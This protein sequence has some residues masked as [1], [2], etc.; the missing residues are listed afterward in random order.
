[1]ANM[2]VTVVDGNNVTVSLDRGVAGVGIASISLVVI[3]QANYLL[4]TYTNGTTQTVGPVGVI[5]YNA[6]SPIDITGSTIS[7]TTVPVNLGG[8]GQTTANAGLNALLPVQTS[9]A[10]KYLQTDGTNSSWDAISL[11]TADITGVLPVVNGG[12]G[13]TTSTGT[14]NTVLSTSPTLV[15]PVL[16]TPASG[17]LTNATGLPV[18]TGISG[19][20]TGIATFLATPSSANLAAALTDG[21]GTGAAVFATSPTLVTPALGTPASGVMTN[22]TGTAAGLTAGNVT[23]NAN[24]TGDITSVGNATAIAAGVIV[25]A[26]INASA[27]IDDTKLATI[28][29]ALK[30]SNSATTAASTNTASAIVARDASGNFT[31]GTVTAAL[32]GNSSTATAL[33][34]G[35]TIEI[36]GDLAY[37]SPSF[38]GTGNVTAAGTL[39]T[40]ATAGVTGSSTA[41][42]VVTINAKGLTTSITTAAVIAPAGTLSG[43]T[44]AA[45]VTGSSLTSLGTIANLSVTAGTISTTPSASTDI[46]NKDYVDNVAQGLDPKASCVAATTAN[47]TLSGTQTIDGVALIAADR[48]L[49]KDQTAPA[50]NGI[51]VVAA[52]AWARAADM[53]VWLEVPGAFT[54]IEQGTLYADTGW[55]CTS[56]AGGTLGTTAITFVQFAGAGS[57]TASTG[58][59]LT[60]TAFSLTAPVTVALGGTNATSAGIASFN[61]ITGYTAA[62]ATGT[63]S[64]NL[65]FSTS[66]TLV[67]PILGTPQSAT[68]TNATGLPISTGVSGM[69]TGIATALAVNVGTAGSPV[70]NG[71]VLGSPST[72]GTM[73][74]FT[75]GGTVSGGGNQINNV[76][77]GASTPLAGAFTTGSFGTNPSATGALRLPNAQAIRWRNAANSADGFYLM[78]SASD[79]LTVFDAANTNI[80]TFSS[81]GLAVTG[82]L[83]ATGV[84]SVTGGSTVYGTAAQFG[85]A[86]AQS[87]SADSRFLFRPNSSTTV[88]GIRIVCNSATRADLEAGIFTSGGVFSTPQTLSLSPNGGLTTIG[89]AISATGVA[90]FSAGTAALPAITTTGD[91]NTGIFFPAADTIAFTEGGAESMRIT[92][93]GSVAIGTTTA[94]STLTVNGTDGI[95]MQRSTANA[96]APVLD[97]LKSRGTTA[98]PAGVSDGD[99][100]FLLRVAPYQGSAFTYLNAMTIE[101]DGTYTAGQNPPTRQIFYTNAANGSATE[102]LRI[103]S[104]GNVGIGTSSPNVKLHVSGTSTTAEI[105]V[106]S[107]STV[108]AL[109]FYADSAT[110]ATRNW[111]IASSFNAFGDLAFQQSNVLG[112]NPLTAGTTRMMLDASGNLG[113][114]TTSPATR[115]HLSQSNAGNYA[116]VI[117]LSNSADSS[118]DRTGIYGSAAPGNALPYRGGITFYPGAS[119]AVSIHT[120]N[121]ASPTTGQAAY[122]SSNQTA[123][124]TASISVGNATPTASGAGITFPATQSASTDANTLDDYEEGTWTPNQ[125]AGLTVVGTFSSTGNYVKVGKMVTVQV[126]LAATTSIT[127]SAGDAIM[128]TN[129]PF[130]SSPTRNPGVAVNTAHQAGLFVNIASTTVYS[131]G[132]LV[133]SATIFLS[134]TYQTS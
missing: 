68:L 60:G 20:G 110:A 117:L 49:V 118:A 76:V 56:N 52:G 13:V 15:T 25:N 43:S 80:G 54:F 30:V 29:T 78:Q 47:I 85:V 23:T 95:T 104:S 50:E 79:A 98:S 88:V 61:N 32:T 105:R 121:N 84:V 73:P 9:Q 64:T 83:S 36:T 62:G 55:V 70:V 11:S 66:P 1:M 2:Q 59:T 22:V 72:A 119:G 90:T 112:G 69:G 40:V 31:A 26:D 87:G 82:T 38:D 4:I 115:L 27:A 21:T 126:S 63:T 133:A 122:F 92:S 6:T 12:T 109:S 28:S 77:I 81:T 51:Y 42:P 113:I 48:C 14:G 93:A 18:A 100:L 74:A 7:L 24:L 103:N 67:T 75:L 107:T 5:Q 123:Q 131:C 97:Y 111:A 106:Q 101:V 53:N 102:R 124:F 19:L 130:A 116:S 132:T 34:T 65:V 125:G 108:P 35:R 16:G 10:N 71:G 96:F 41:I 8:T 99:G 129:L 37:T 57:Y 86:D 17:T 134:I 58:L 44:L 3:N 91:T 46:A 89:G 39:A 45:G 120:G 127:I 128:F 33:A 114:G 94:L